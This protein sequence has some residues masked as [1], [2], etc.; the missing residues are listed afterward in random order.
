EYVRDELAARPATSRA[1]EARRAELLGYLGEYIAKG[2]TPQNTFVP[3]RNPVFID[4]SGNICAVGYLIERSIGRAVPEAIAQAHRLDYLEDIAVAMPEVAAWIASSGFTVDELASIQPGYPGPEV[5]HLMGWLTRRANP[6]APGDTDGWQD[7]LGEALPENGPYRQEID[8]TVMQG[9]FARKQ[10]VGVWTRKREGRILGKGTF[11]RGAATWESFRLDGSRLAIGPFA[12]SHAEGEWKIFHPS[13]RL[14]AVGTMRDGQRHGTW[15]FFYDNQAS[16]KLAVGPFVQGHTVGG[17]K[18]FDEVGALVAKTKGAAWEGITLEIEPNAAGVRHEIHQGIPAEDNRLD[19]LYL[20]KD[21]LYVNEDGEMFDGDSNQ[22][23]KTETG[24]VAR[25]CKWS[26]K[27]KAAARAGNASTLHDMMLKERWKD[28]EPA[29]DQCT[30]ASVAV[31]AARASRYELMIRSRWQTHAPIPAWDIDP[32]PAAPADPE[33]DIDL[34]VNDEDHDD[35]DA[36]GGADNPLDMATYL[37]RHA[38]WY[39]EWPHVDATFVALYRSLP[40]YVTT[41]G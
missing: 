18:H 40:G 22:L 33:E 14:A 2:I 25:A 35:R 30:G 12:N 29:V 5:M 3:F 10:M 41:E 26:K 28:G 9:R 20:G 23:E 32:Q 37:T 7:P 4:A 16:S 11:R 1:L 17:W 31:S 6:N 8:G 19:G 38:T 21:R 15:K 24:W 34:G 27:R 13:G 39:I 36:I